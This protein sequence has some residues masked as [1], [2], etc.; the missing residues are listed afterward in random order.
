MLRVLSALFAF[1]SPAFSANLGFLTAFF[2]NSSV[3]GE[4]LMKARLGYRPAARAACSGWGSSCG[5]LQ[6]G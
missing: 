5:Q 1:D 4:G 2:A 3:L 6:Q